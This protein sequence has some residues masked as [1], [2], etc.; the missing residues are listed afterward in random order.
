[1]L[2]IFRCASTSMLRSLFAK[3]SHRVSAP[4]FV[5][6]SSICYEMSSL[7]VAL[8]E[9]RKSQDAKQ[10]HT[11]VVADPQMSVTDLENAIKRFLDFKKSTDL[12]GLIRTPLSFSGILNWHTVPHADHLSKTSHLMYDM[13][14]VARNG[15]VQSLKLQKAIR[16]LHEK[17]LCDFNRD[18]P[19]GDWID[20]CD[21]VIR[22]LLSQ[23]R[24][25]KRE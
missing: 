5:F 4:F 10:K 14:L 22:V 2:A 12:H 19:V 13:M 24:L 15:K 9:R 6:W 7:E 16:S 1:M 11:R 21:H 25:L 18:K 8:S 23:Y 3:V 20:S 17:R